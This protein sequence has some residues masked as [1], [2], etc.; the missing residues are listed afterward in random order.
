[1]NMRRR[2]LLTAF[3]L[4]S[5]V[6]PPPPSPPVAADLAPAPLAPL[7]PSWEEVAAQAPAPVAAPSASFGWQLDA[8]AESQPLSGD[9]T[10]H[11]LSVSKNGDSVDL[12]LV[13]FDSRS[14]ELKIIDQPED[15]AGAGQI[16]ACMRLAGA[17]AGVNG[18]FFTPQFTPMGLMIADGNPTGTWQ[19]NKL[20]TGAV[21]VRHSPQLLW[22]SEALKSRSARHLIQTG[23]RLVDS[24][25]P[26]ASLERRKHVP[27]TFVATDGSHRWIFGLARHTSLGE[28]AEI[29][30]T[31]DLL[32]GFQVHRALNLDGGRSSAIYYRT[33][34]GREQSAPGWSTVR[35]YLA[36][37]L[38]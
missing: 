33:A 34:D 25:K 2:L 18:G 23:P 21:V 36:I 30:A 12:Q 5:C 28:L 31:P 29:L 24:G 20:L 1:M 22:N 35:N 38:R 8:P 6:Q 10:L 26:V 9:A 7:Y 11:T 14:H 27:R 17:I 19:S 32:P 3:A 4:S 16:T 15:G 37:V 13:Y